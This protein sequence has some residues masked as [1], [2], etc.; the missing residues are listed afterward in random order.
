MYRTVFWTLC[1]GATLYY[2]QDMKIKTIV[3]LHY[4]LIRMAKI[5]NVEKDVEQQRS[6]YIANGNAK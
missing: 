5:Q 4:T 1:G 6:S 2:H 3:R